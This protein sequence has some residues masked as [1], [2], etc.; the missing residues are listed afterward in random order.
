MIKTNALCREQCIALR[1]HCEDITSNN[2]RGTFFAI[3]KLKFSEVN[4]ELK[5]HSDSPSTKN[6]A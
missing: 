1:E 2:N 4:S 3:L 6:T 5:N